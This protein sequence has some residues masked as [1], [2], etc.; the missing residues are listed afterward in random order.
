M[1]ADINPR[2]GWIYGEGDVTSLLETSASIDAEIVPLSGWE[3]AVDQG[4]QWTAMIVELSRNVT[5]IK[6]LIQKT[7]F[8]GDIPIIAIV[9][10]SQFE[11]GINAMAAGASGV[12]QKEELTSTTLI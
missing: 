5:V 6:Q 7:D 9:S 2:I 4:G 3:E 11:T 10:G 8:S 1:S 12:I